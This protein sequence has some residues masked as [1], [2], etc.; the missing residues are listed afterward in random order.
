[1]KMLADLSQEELNILIEAYIEGEDIK[2]FELDY[3][4]NDYSFMTR[5]IMKTND[6]NFYDLSSDNLKGSFNFVKFLVEK[7]G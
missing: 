7:F 3:L 6:K 2:V 4:E 1:M 5:V